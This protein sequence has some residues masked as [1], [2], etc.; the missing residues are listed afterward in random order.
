MTPDYGFC[1]KAGFGLNSAR[2]SWRITRLPGRRDIDRGSAD[3]NAPAGPPCVGIA[4]ALRNPAPA[5]G[6][7]KSLDIRSGCAVNPRVFRRRDVPQRI[8]RGTPG[9]VMLR[10]RTRAAHAACEQ[11]LQARYP[12]KQGLASR[13]VPVLSQAAAIHIHHAAPF[14]FLK[15]RAR[16]Q[17][18]SGGIMTKRGS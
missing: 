3:T 15:H 5:A 12:F 11:G 9:I 6:A 8:R 2:E 1:D 4:Q 7:G 16:V 14:R 13:D 17:C 10:E 18:H